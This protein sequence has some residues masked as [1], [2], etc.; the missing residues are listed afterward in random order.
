MEF[1]I[2]IK[3]TISV[4]RFICTIFIKIF[5][6]LFEHLPFFVLVTQRGNDVGVYDDPIGHSPVFAVAVLLLTAERGGNGRALFCIPKAFLSKTE[7]FSSWISLFLPHIF[8]FV[9]PLDF[10]TFASSSSSQPSI[11]ISSYMMI[12]ISGSNFISD[13]HFLNRFCVAKP[14]WVNM[15]INLLMH[16]SFD[17]AIKIF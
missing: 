2:F 7:I 10:W 4:T 6:V 5:C 16:T 9:F 17:M 8:L 12:I 15:W 3:F 1:L 14:K 13:G 11:L